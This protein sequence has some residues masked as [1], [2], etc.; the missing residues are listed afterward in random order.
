MRRAALLLSVLLLLGVSALAQER[1][2][3]WSAQ[4]EAGIHSSNEGRMRDA[5]AIFKK[6]LDEHPRAYDVYGLYWETLGRLET[7][8]AVSRAVT[9]PGTA[10][11]SRA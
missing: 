10:C 5:A 1:P 6:I 8:A 7:P 4:L 2:H 3:P 11:G 9:V